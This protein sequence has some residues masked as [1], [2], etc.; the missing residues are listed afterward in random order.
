[1]KSPVLFLIFNRPDETIRVFQEIK[2]AQPEKLFIAA[3]GPREKIYGEKEKCETSRKIIEFI[4]WKCEVRT[5][6]REHNLGCG[7]AVSSAITWFFEQVDEGIILEDD[8]LPNQTFFRF[9]DE[10]L[11]KY[12][13]NETIMHIT[14]TNLVNK[15]IS[16][17]AS[18]YFS[19]YSNI[20]GW[21]TWKRAWENYNFDMTGFEK[22]KENDTLLL[23]FQDRIIA[24]FHL[25]KLQKT[26]NKEIDTWD[27]QW[28]YAI[29]KNH[30]LSI[31]PVRNL[32]INIGFGVSATHTKDNFSIANTRNYE[33]DEIVHPGTVKVN[34]KVDYD[35]FWHLI[36]FEN[37]SGYVVHS[38]KKMLYIVLNKFY[39]IILRK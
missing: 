24:D 12:R 4:D 26:Y 29:W 21:A 25:S 33:F 8:C 22:F 32:I 3:D 38:L 27:Y 31:I 18:Y 36:G 1:L 9:C 7:K 23:L 11:H 16:G 10:L 2:K 15:D 19:N 14:G 35:F 5:L 20:W 37:K 13:D 6:F 30:G 28:S 34:H 17:S 39:K